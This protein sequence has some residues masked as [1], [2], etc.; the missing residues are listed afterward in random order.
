MIPALLIALMFGALA[1]QG[2]MPRFGPDGL[3]IELCSGVGNTTAT[4]ARDD[5]RYADYLALQTARTGEPTQDHD[6][7]E[8]GSMPPCAFASLAM[9]A[10]DADP[11][12]L[13]PLLFAREIPPALHYALL[14]ARHHAGTPPAT[15]PPALS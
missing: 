10:V 12:A 5:P 9:L 3:T 4:I 8:D 14:R 7:S 1:P 11:V 15:G 6:R 13:P 2:F